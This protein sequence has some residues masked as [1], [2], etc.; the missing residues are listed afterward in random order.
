MNLNELTRFLN[1]IKRKLFML[2]GKALI[3]AVNSTGEVG[4]YPAGDRKNPQ[5]VSMNWLGNLTDI[6]HSQPFGFEAR[7]LVGT[8]KA[9][10]LSPDGSRSN[11]FVIMVQD[12]E[13][14]PDDLGEGDSCLYDDSNIRVWAK[15][16]KLVIGKKGTPMISTPPATNTEA[17]EI[18]DRFM[19][20]F[21]GAINLP[22]VASGTTLL[23]TVITE[24]GKL[25]TDLG[26]IKG[27]F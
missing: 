15:D 10:I 24:I 17:L 8:A 18:M 9:I 11:A 6:E 7:S 4:F 14:R 16:G 27:S 1:P 5:R 19:T 26:N 22:G 12:D 13:Y 25:R 21:E 3:T 20:I 23:G 2:V